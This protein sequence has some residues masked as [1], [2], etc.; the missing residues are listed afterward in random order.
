MTQ[1]NTNRYVVGSL[2]G[3]SFSLYDLFGNPVD[4]SA[5]GTYVS[6]GVVNQISYPATAPI[7]NPTNGQIVT[8]G[9]PAG[10][11]YDIG[12]EGLFLGSAMLGADGNVIWWE[13]I[14]STPTGW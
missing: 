14:Y 10:N 4:T 1:L 8:P 3:T 2:S 5:F 6:G 7:L 13:A 12:F 11:Q 9:Q